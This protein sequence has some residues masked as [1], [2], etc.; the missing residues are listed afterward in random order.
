MEEKSKISLNYHK[1]PT[2]SILLRSSLERLLNLLSG[3]C[4]PVTSPRC[5]EKNGRY[6]D[7]LACDRER[8]PCPA[9][10]EAGKDHTEKKT[11][12]TLRKLNNCIFT[13]A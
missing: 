4:E 6:G 10:T 13:K 2:L 11:H 9:L 3:I 1:I 5:K 12:K 8:Q 7:E